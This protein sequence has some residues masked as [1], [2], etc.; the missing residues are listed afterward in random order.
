MEKYP[1]HEVEPISDFK[2]LLRHAQSA[3]GDRDIFRIRTKDGGIT[4][5]GWEKLSRD[6]N[7]LGNGL[8]SLG[9]AGQKVAII[10][11]TSYEWLLSYYT[12]TCGI[13]T[14]VPVDKE[15]PDDEIANILCDSGAKC[16][17]YSPEY[18]DTV[19][20]IR[21]NGLADCVSV[22][23][24]MSGG[25]DMGSI[26]TML[27]G[28]EDFGYAQRKVDPHAM[29]ILLYTSGTTGK[30]KGVMLT[31]HNILRASEGAL[32]LLDIG[33][34]CMSVL[35]VHHSYESTHGITMMIEHG[36]TICISDSLRNFLPNLQLFKPDMIFLVPLFVEMMYRKIW[37]NARANG[38]EDALRAL[39]EKSNAELDRGIDN[40]AKYFKNIH[41]AFG[42]KLNLIICGGA[43]LAS[44]LSR[45]FRE[46]GILLLQGYG[47]TECSPLVAVNRN[48]YYKD[49][50]IGLPIACCDVEIR[51]KDEN[52]EGEIWV[53]GEN[54]ML[55]YY[56]NEEGTREV[57]DGEWFNTGDIGHVDQDGFLF[58]T[59][60]KKNLI[61]L[62]NGKNVYPEEIEDYLLRIPYI[63]EVV[64][65]AP[66][67]EGLKEVELHA[68]LFLNEDYTAEHS[69][70]EISR[71]LEKD[72][73]AVNKTLPTYKQVQHWD[74][75]DKEFEKT[76]KKSIKR[77]TV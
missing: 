76:T 69:A 70:D 9:L 7:A 53:R 2:E 20:N 48:R 30:S 1:L 33:E 50:S 18:E 8:L 24:P 56:K 16:L 77:F 36:T 4:G 54:V 13:G 34:V 35:P 52:G 49:G 71:R 64:V 75:R 27:E 31:Q 38:Q 43:P 63:K 39:I 66:V 74:I 19:Q 15:L 28:T 61:V 55:G 67:V 46:M 45:A 37:A 47:I 65:F 58:I 29:T 17:I 42:G 44:Y 23:L 59:G 68:E 10:G 51:E 72:I 21:T 26:R 22:W 57:M 11:P 40:R 62:T 3:Y 25:A 41:N 12:I 5:I 73:A 32:R 14:V 6:I 60:R